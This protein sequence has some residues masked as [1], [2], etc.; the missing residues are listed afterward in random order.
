MDFV[1]V[2]GDTGGLAEG[3]SLGVEVV[4]V[5]VVGDLLGVDVVGLE[6]G[7][8]VVGDSLGVE[9]VGVTVVV[10]LLGV[11]V[12]GLKVP[13]LYH[14][15]LNHSLLWQAAIWMQPHTDILCPHCSL[16]KLCLEANLMCVSATWLRLGK[17]LE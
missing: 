7:L 12:V 17:N 6:V 2:V 4:R 13:W 5:T 16:W 10:D 14:I 3:L 15:C 8:E 9:V 11:D 1:D